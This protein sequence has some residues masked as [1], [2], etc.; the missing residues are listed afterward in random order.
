MKTFI[1]KVTVF[2][3][4][5]A[6]GMGLVI[7]VLDLLNGKLVHRKVR[8]IRHPMVFVG[9]SHIALAVNDETM[10]GTINMA[11]SAEPIGYTYQKLKIL[12]ESNSGIERV[13]L[14]FGY[15]NIAEGFNDFLQRRTSVSNNYFYLLSLEE[16]IKVMLS[17]GRHSVNHLKSV[18]DLG[19]ENIR[20]QRSPYDG[21]YSNPFRE[22][23][24]RKEDMDKRLQI[25]F[26]DKPGAGTF[27]R[28]S[29]EYLA[30]I[31]DLCRRHGVRLTLLN[32]PLH[33]YYRS[34]IPEKYMARYR[35]VTD[36]LGMDV[37][38]LTGLFDEEHMF[39]ADGDHV[40]TEGALATSRHIMERMYPETPEG[41][42]EMAEGKGGAEELVRYS[43]GG[44]RR[45]QGS[46]NP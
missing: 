14:G 45:P 44:S 16:K 42:G 37:M 1:L 2:L 6:A 19:F 4:I 20:R 43:N 18:I 23:T 21:G 24:A 8:D 10:D 41:G 17:W 22:T 46:R 7:A 30:R 3:S 32:T 25:Q 15:H 5:L 36:S 26:S 12:L 33:P 28:S 13:F 38:D 40:S 39:V 34:N 11:R 27:S 9:D 29:I 31:R 35:Q